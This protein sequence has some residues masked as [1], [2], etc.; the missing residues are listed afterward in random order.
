MVTESHGVLLE[1]H[2]G[3]VP[4]GPIGRGFEGTIF[5]GFQGPVVAGLVVQE[6]LFLELRMSGSWGGSMWRRWQRSRAASWRGRL[7]REVHRS[8]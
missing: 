4:S 8:S 5:A 1:E 2:S 6:G 7:V 3:I